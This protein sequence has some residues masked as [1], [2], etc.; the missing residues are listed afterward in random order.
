MA[1]HLVTGFKGEAHITPEDVG[2]FNAGTFGDGDYVLNIGN[3]FAAEVVSNNTVKILDGDLIMQG[4]HI[5]LMRGTHEE[6]NINNGEFGLNRNDI[7]VVRYTKDAQSGIENAEFAI[8]QGTSTDGVAADPEL[9]TGDILAGNCLIHEMPLYRIPLTGFTVGEPE[10]MFKSVDGLHK[11]GG[12][13]YRGWNPL[14]SIDEDNPEKWVELGNGFWM[15]DID[16]RIIGQPNRWGFLYNTVSE[17]GE[18]A[19]TFVVQ[20][21]GETYRRNANGIGWY[22]TDWREGTWIAMYDETKYFQTYGTYSGNGEESQFV[23]LGFTPSAVYVARS[24]GSTARTGWTGGYGSYF[25]GGLAL[26][27]ND[28]R[29]WNSSIGD[30]PIVSI[31]ENGFNVYCFEHNVSGSGYAKIGTNS[32]GTF[33]YIAYR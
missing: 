22:G 15:I 17:S 21:S 27:N 29:F 2:A 11:H 33:L 10:T 18:I 5:T 20:A 23:E 13:M 6:L 32:S 8:V 14:S 16:G 28:C 30:K 19:Q 24:D 25:Y 1:L 9:S 3:A 12:L 4:R 31:A 26:K 7:V